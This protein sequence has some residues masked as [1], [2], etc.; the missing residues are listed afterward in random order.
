M[1]AHV[2]DQSAAPPI[3]RRSVARTRIVAVVGA[4]LAALAGWVVAVPIS[5]L[6]LEVASG[7]TT[8]TVGAAA[9]LGAGF[10][11]SLLGWALLALLERRAPR[12][13]GTWTAIAVAAL[14]LSL[15]GPL[16][17]DATAA[18]K[19]T[20]ALLHVVV[21]AVLIPVLRRTSRTRRPSRS[22]PRE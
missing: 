18:T 19:V 5:G 11:A 2:T 13:K 3:A 22:R 6:D 20:L 21:A 1:A 4:T 14:L 9:V 12:A 10:T 16:G 7:A 17:V 8:R 15:V